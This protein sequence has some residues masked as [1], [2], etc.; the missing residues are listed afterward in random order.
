MT[1]ICT[2]DQTTRISWTTRKTRIRELDPDDS[3]IKYSNCVKRHMTFR[4]LEVS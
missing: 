1:R 4:P 3:E 2:L